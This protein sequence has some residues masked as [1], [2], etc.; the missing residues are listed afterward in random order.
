MSESHMPDN[1]AKLEKLLRA[2]LSPARDPLFRIAV[3]ARRERQRFRRRIA[4]TVA[5]GAAATALVAVNAA[6]IS[7][8]LAEDVTRLAVVLAVAAAAAWALPGGSHV[9]PSAL[10]RLVRACWVR[11]TNYAAIGSW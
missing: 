3:L 6:A 2:E 4:A 1:E 5:V 11:I 8:W 10:R 7:A 9:V